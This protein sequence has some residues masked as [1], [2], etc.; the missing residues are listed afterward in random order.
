MRSYRK[1]GPPDWQRRLVL[2]LWGLFGAT[3]LLFAVWAM[4]LWIETDR[5][6]DCVE[7]GGRYDAE[8]DLCEGARWE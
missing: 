3:L 1:T 7:R 5:L 2:F 6:E 8:A 4:L